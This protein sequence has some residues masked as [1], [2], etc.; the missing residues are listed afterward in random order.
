[1]G[2]APLERECNFVRHECACLDGLQQALGALL[3]ARHNGDD[4]LPHTKHHRSVNTI[5][6]S[7]TCSPAIF[8]WSVS[9]HLDTQRE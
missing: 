2:C 3:C 4:Q 8:D 6:T 5:C 9:H 1:M 7:L